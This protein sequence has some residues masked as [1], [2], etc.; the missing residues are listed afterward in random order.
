MH[1]MGTMA[2]GILYHTSG[3][4]RDK[5]DVPKDEEG[6]CCLRKSLNMCTYMAFRTKAKGREQILVKKKKKGKESSVSRS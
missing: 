6:N 1:K 5:E 4:L 2:Q 3:R